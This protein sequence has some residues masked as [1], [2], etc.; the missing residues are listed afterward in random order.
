MLAAGDDE[1]TLRLWNVETGQ[2]K[3]SFKGHTLAIRSV[4][5]SPDDKTLLSGS[6]DRTARLW[7]VVTGQELLVLKGH[8]SPVMLV[9]FAPDGKRVAT[10]SGAE[11]KLWLAATEPEAT[12]FRGELDPDDPDSPRTMNNWGDRLGEIHQPQEAEIAYRKARA[13]LEKLAAALEGTPDCRLELAYCLLAPTLMTDPPPAAAPSGRQFAEIWRTLPA[14]RQFRLGKRFLSSGYTLRTAGRFQEAL[15]VYQ[16]L[17]ELMPSDPVVWHQLGHTHQQSDQPEKAIAAYSR[18]IDVDPKNMPSWNNRGSN[19]YNLRQ[20]DKAITD[21]RQAIALDPN[22]PAPHINLGN[23]L[24]AQGKSNDAIAAYRQGLKALG[25]DDPK[26]LDIQRALVKTYQS[27]GNLPEVIGLLEQICDHRLEKF[28]PNHADTLQSMNEL[29]VAFW[30]AKQLDRSIS[31]F[32]ETVRLM[33]ANLPPDDP[34]TYT[35]IAN[36][37]VNYRDAGRLR[38]AI[39]QLEE[40]I[41]W[42]RK[43]P[44]R[45]ANQFAWV[46]GALSETYEQDQQ[47]AK[48][49]PLRREGLQ[50]ARQQFGNT[51]P[52]TAGPLALLGLN[53]LRQRKYAEAEPLLRDCLGLREKAEPDVWTTFNARSMLGGSLLGQKKYA[54]AEPLLRQGYEGMKQ[55]EAKIPPLGKPRLRETVERLVQLYDD[56]GQPEKS[57]EWRK[58]LAQEEREIASFKKAFEL[59]GKATEGNPNAV[60]QKPSDPERWL[61]RAHLR[62]RRGDW[63]GARQDFVEVINLRPNDLVLLGR[64]A[65]FYLRNNRGQDAAEVYDRAIEKSPSNAALKARRRQLQPGV[66]AVWNFDAGSEDWGSPHQ[67]TVSASGGVLHI[68]TTGDDPWVI[69]P[70]AAPAGWKELTLHVRTDREC[71][72]QLF[73]AR[74]RTPD[75]AEERSVLFDVKP[76]KG[77]WTQVKVRFRADTALTALRL[78]PVEGRKVRWEIDAATLANVAPPAEVTARGPCGFSAPR[79]GN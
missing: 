38:D 49:E 55:R 43:Q 4:A 45:V 52:R 25:S 12:A 41:E 11:V 7:D 51:D 71:Q 69:V 27:L 60:E 32:E 47:F 54:E 64:I 76:G 19:Y 17:T 23:A 66:V 15:R 22:E 78:D 3:V 42:A 37:G 30:R 21:F 33:R 57:A 1:G 68:Q 72:A 18:A 56:W 63:E 16:Q 46:T 44:A 8:K 13:R 26:A 70:V 40:V 67:C 34:T 28:G 48:A 29:G 62:A 24:R 65:G 9:A 35:S 39:P 79:R 50:R 74:Q 2:L 10:A 6:A 5:F 77:E 58:K 73:W 14:D 61:R 53:L 31:L 75:F 59:K 36:L 20:F